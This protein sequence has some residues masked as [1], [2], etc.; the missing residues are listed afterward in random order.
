MTVLVIYIRYINTSRYANN[1]YCLFD[2]NDL[3]LYP[4]LVSYQTSDMLPFP[5]D[6]PYFSIVLKSIYYVR[7]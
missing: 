5:I 6:Q 7:H 4:S 2:R 1:N 3:V